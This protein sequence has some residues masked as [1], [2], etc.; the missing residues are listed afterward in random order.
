MVATEPTVLVMPTKGTRQRCGEANLD[1]GTGVD[2]L[3][4]IALAVAGWSVAV[5]S[6]FG[7]V[8]CCQAA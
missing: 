3:E 4:R 1:F 7:V 8:L 6:K 2:W 5:R